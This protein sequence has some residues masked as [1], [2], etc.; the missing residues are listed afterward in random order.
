MTS[1]PLA[2][3]AK[4]ILIHIQDSNSFTVA[5]AIMALDVPA[6]T[7]NRG[8]GLVV[9]CITLMVVII[10]ATVLRIVSMFV[11]KRKWWWDDFFAIY[12]LVRLT[13]T[14]TLVPRLVL[15]RRNSLTRSPC[16]PLSLPGPRLGLASTPTWSRA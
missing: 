5:T 6:G 11:V 12:S 9:M 7:P 3:I 14:S 1:S 15:T 8:P 16:S 13:L 2:R 10:L 4:V